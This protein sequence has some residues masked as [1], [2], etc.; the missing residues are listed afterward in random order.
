MQQPPADKLETVQ[1]GVVAGYRIGAFSFRH[2]DDIQQREVKMNERRF[3]WHR[4]CS[5]PVFG[6]FLLA[7]A[8]LGIAAFF[9]TLPSAIAAS[10][11]RQQE[12]SLPD[13]Q[14]YAAWHESWRYVVLEDARWNCLLAG[15]ETFIQR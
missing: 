6:I 13:W 15:T 14:R 7:L 2:G 1:I 12:V 10:A 8:V 9:P 5:L 4:V 11:P 3:R